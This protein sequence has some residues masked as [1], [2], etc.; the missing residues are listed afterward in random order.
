[1]KLPKGQVLLEILFFNTICILF[2]VMQ[3]LIKRGADVRRRPESGDSLLHM[4]A[5][6]GSRQCCDLLT[7]AGH[8]LDDVNRDSNTPLHCAVKNKQVITID[9]VHFHHMSAY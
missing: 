9:N 7:R 6:G 5:L 4:A 1:M 3:Y 2:Q 8:R